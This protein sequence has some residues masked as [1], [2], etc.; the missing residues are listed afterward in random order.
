MTKNWLGKEAAFIGG[1]LFILLPNSIIFGA[2]SLDALFAV[3]VL[4]TLFFLIKAFNNE[5]ARK[6]AMFSGLLLGL[7]LF[8]SFSAVVYGFF[9]LLLFFLAV[10]NDKQTRGKQYLASFAW[11]ATGFL[12]F[13]LLLTFFTGFRFIPTFLTAVCLEKELL[14]KAVG[15]STG[16]SLSDLRCYT[17]AGNIL[18]FSLYTGFPVI[19]L[20]L[21]SVISGFHKNP[22]Q[23]NLLDLFSIASFLLILTITISNIY[24]LETG[25]IWFFISLLLIVPASQRIVTIK[26]A[27]LKHKVLWV[28]YIVLFLQTGIFE[29]LF[30]TIW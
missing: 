6:N 29:I 10:C 8:M 2:V 28:V 22:K 1:G 4:W 5:S 3:P 19:A 9:I 15:V 11:V 16:Y 23:K 18:A 12:L 21:R 13:V 30:F 7:A 20:W 27:F 17:M 26:N 25:R 14:H 24:H